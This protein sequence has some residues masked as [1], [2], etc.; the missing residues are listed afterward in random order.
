MNDYQAGGDPDQTD[1]RKPTEPMSS[2]SPKKGLDD[3]RA[4][5]ILTTEHWSLLSTRA[6]GYQEMFG[7]TTIF[8]AVLS[9]TIVALALL[10][11]AMRFGREI[12]LLAL[13]LLC[14]ALFIGLTTFVRSVA[15]NF[16]D[17]RW[18]TGMELLR[19]AY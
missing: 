10:A 5:D 13:L 19:S 8:V 14:V 4:L 16:E 3:P 18:V 11:Q 17:A 15:I 2:D 9:A 1:P 7:R 12:L 6:L